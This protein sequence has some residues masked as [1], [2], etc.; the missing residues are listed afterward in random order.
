MEFANERVS[1][2]C[3]GDTRMRI[4]KQEC[5]GKALP[6]SQLAGETHAM[7]TTPPTSWANVT[8]EDVRGIKASS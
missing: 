4:F 5:F 2:D 3:T 8:I 6:S 1:K 7:P